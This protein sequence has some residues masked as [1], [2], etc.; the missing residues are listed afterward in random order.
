MPEMDDAGHTVFADPSDVEATMIGK[1]IERQPPADEVLDVAAGAAPA[2]AEVEPDVDIFDDD[3]ATALSPRQQAE[4]AGGETAEDI[5]SEAETGLYGEPSAAADDG[6]EFMTV[7]PSADPDETSEEEFDAE[8]SAFFSDGSMGPAVDQ[9]EDIDFDDDGPAPATDPGVAL[10]GLDADQG[11]DA[12]LLPDQVGG[13]RQSTM[14]SILP[15]KAPYL[16]PMGPSLISMVDQ[17]TMPATTTKT[18]KGRP[19]SISSRLTRC[20]CP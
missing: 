3:V 7:G 18:R 13:H 14:Y 17:M 6:A 4:A 9:E 11:L 20:E 19:C 8:A 10:A 16:R 5:D 12:T 15:V 2:M 1:V